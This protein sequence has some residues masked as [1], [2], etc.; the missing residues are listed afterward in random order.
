[1]TEALSLLNPTDFDKLLQA[2]DRSG[3][4]YR[5]RALLHLFWHFGPSPRQVLA[6]TMQDVNFLAARVRWP[7]GGEQPLPPEVLQALTSYIS[8]ERD[9]RCARLFCGRRGRPL[10]AVQLDAFFRRL[11]ALSGVPVTPRI[12]RMC[13]L[14]RM[15]RTNPVRAMTAVMGRRPAR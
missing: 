7:R 11:R 6:L 14:F 5:D 4:P 15:L 3:H 13:A 9:A 1:M 2:A 10:T 8:F 12:L